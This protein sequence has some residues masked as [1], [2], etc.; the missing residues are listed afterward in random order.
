MRKL[1]LFIA[2]GFVTSCTSEEELVEQDI[3]IDFTGSYSGE[4]TCVGELGDDAESTAIRIEKLDDNLQT[5]SLFFEDDVT[6]EGVQ[7]EN[8]L[9]I[10]KQIF[11]EGGE[12]DVITMEGRI[13][14]ME[15]AAFLFE[16]TYSVDDEGESTCQGT[17]VK[18]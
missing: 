5:Y 18:Q 15:N 11:N 7:Q 10:E 8:M 6:F 3:T 13:E 9:L 14:A 4:L 16:N 17:L 12:F 1:L 2:F